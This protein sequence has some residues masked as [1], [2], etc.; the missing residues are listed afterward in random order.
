[1]TPVSSRR[2]RRSRTAGAD[3]PT[4][5]ASSAALALG[6]A[7]SASR[8]RTLT[9]PRSGFPSG[10][11]AGGLGDL[12]V[13]IE[14]LRLRSSMV[15]GRFAFDPRGMSSTS[16]PVASHRVPPHAYFVVSAVFHYLGPAFAVL[17]FARVDALGVAW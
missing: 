10:R 4:C 13:V 2:A 5:R 3:M 9:A 16:P 15:P 14:P 1:M 6:S 17:L 12:E 8:S 11:P 7:L